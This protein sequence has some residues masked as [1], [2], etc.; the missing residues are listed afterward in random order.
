LAVWMASISRDKAATL[1]LVVSSGSRAYAPLSAL[2]TSAKEPNCGELY[3][4]LQ[5]GG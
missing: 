2:A 5:A 3:S 4:R 1:A